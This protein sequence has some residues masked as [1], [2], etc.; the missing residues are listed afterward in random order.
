MACVSL[1][2][3]GDE[4]LAHIREAF[5]GAAWTEGIPLLHPWANRLGGFS[6]GDVVLDP[7]SPELHIEEHGLPL[8]GLRSAVR[9]WTLTDAG[10]TRL[11]A[12][13]E[14]DLREFPFPHRIEVEARL[15]SGRLTLATTVTATGARAVPISF[16]YHPYLVL[17]GV[18]RAEWEVTVPVSAHLLLD[19]HLIPTG[20]REPAGDLDGPLGSRTFDNGYAG[21]GGPFAVSGGGRRIEVTFEAGYG[22]AQVFAPGEYDVVCFE[23]MTAP[24]DA[25]RHSPDTVAP[26]ESFTARFSVSVSRTA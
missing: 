24:A 1:R 8:H 12:G 18:P 14:L 3:D 16:G 13:R 10:P 19:E 2:H 25:L 23:P 17:P 20:A 15:H 4:L 21:V 5:P 22:F 9:G 7:G 6:Y 11:V 26:G